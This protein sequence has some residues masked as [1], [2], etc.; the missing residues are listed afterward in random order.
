MLTRIPGH[1]PFYRPASNSKT[2]CE[3][4]DACSDKLPHSYTHNQIYPLQKLKYVCAAKTHSKTDAFG[5]GS[6]TNTII[7]G[8][9]YSAFHRG[10]AYGMRG[11]R[12][13]NH[14]VE[15]LEFS[16]GR[17][18]LHEEKHSIKSVNSCS[19]PLL[20]IH[21]Q[22]RSGIYDWILSIWWAFQ[23]FKNKGVCWVWMAF[24]SLILK[25]FSRKSTARF[26]VICSSLNQ[27]RADT[28]SLFDP[29]GEL[30]TLFHN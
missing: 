11:W 17:V 18:A 7:S 9:F 19:I 27:K 13:C 28:P 20:N 4:T 5:P 8:C 26:S 1:I 22:F 12:L 24:C 2:R 15:T 10:D 14:L 16:R 23:S 21:I 30:F 3:Q 29:Q 6:R 25:C